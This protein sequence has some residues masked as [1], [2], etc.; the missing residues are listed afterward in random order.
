MH[1]VSINNRISW[2]NAVKPTASEVAELARQF[3]LHPLIASEL[4]IPSSR[5]RVER[6]DG[7]L[8]FVY[9]LPVY[10]EATKTSRVAE[11][12]IVATEETLVTVS[13]EAL[14]PIRQFGRAF[15]LTSENDIT[16]T[17]ELVYRL[18]G[19][20]NEFSVRELRHV[21]EKVRNVGRELFTKPDPELLES[22]SHIKR[23]L[24]EFSL[25]ATTQRSMLDS[26]IETGAG[27]WGEAYRIYL[28][29]LRSDFG[30]TYMLLENLKASVE[31]YSETVSQLFQ[32]KTSELMSRFTILGFLTFPLILYTTI[33]LQPNVAPTFL[34]SPIDFWLIF[35]G[36]VV[37]VV[38]LA[39]FFRKKGWF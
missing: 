13:Y 10:D 27:F 15:E 36:I 11:I 2:L 24:L 29:D 31:S 16:S 19:A 35:A 18:I 26:L 38:G 39:A 9:H 33:A 1:A 12:D 14:E 6:H 21:E 25:I 5:S 8:Y 28:Q 3:F 22:I 34:Q 20:A 30:K 7:Y 4:G 32:F 17:A 23:D 37:L